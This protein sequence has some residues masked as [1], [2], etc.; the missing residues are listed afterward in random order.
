[1]KKKLLLVFVFLNT[2]ICFAQSNK[3]QFEYNKQ[4]V[5]GKLKTSLNNLRDYI[6]VKN[7]NNEELNF[8]IAQI[9]DIQINDE[10][11]IAANVLNDATLTKNIDL[12]D[13]LSE[14]NYKENWLLLKVI[15]N[16]DYNLYQYSSSIFSQ[17]YYK[18]SNTNEIKPLVYK[19]YIIGSSV[20]KNNHFRSQLRKDIP[21]YYYVFNDYE[22]L[23]YKYDDLLKYFNKLNGYEENVGVKKTNVK[24]SVLVGL[25]NN[26]H[27]ELYFADTA[28]KRLYLN[29]YE[30]EKKSPLFFGVSGEVFLDKNE[31]N[32]IFIDLGF[33]HYKTSYYLDYYNSVASNIKFEY[34]SNIMMVNFG[35]KRYFNISSNSKI[36]AS[37]SLSPNFFFTSKNQVSYDFFDSGYDGL[38]NYYEETYNL[39]VKRHKNSSNLGVRFSMGYKFKNHYF[40]EVNYRKG[41]NSEYVNF[42]HE[43]TSFVLGYTF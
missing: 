18:D 40:A 19:E 5:S 16:G 7:D 30:L 32:A 1:M 37:A 3:I 24:L 13:H 38:G 27:K 12:L 23:E 17:F 15:V 35:Y 41:A 11:F 4:I 20:K 33:M 43:I 31:L 8:N 10:S 6:V 25:A 34:K 21:L 14:P 39:S 42:S 2:L 28:I 29:D 36:Y 9:K 22:K 26:F